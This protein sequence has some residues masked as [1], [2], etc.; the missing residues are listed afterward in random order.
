ME[1]T[2]N[3]NENLINSESIELKESTYHIPVYKENS[4]EFLR[5]LAKL[6]KAGTLIGAPAPPVKHS[7]NKIDI[8]LLGKG[9]TGYMNKQPIAVIN[10]PKLSV[11]Y[12]P[13]FFVIFVKNCKI[14]I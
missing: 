3:N 7:P 5:A 11:P 13:N 14:N 12:I 9:G 8:M 6:I 2:D 4:K 1:T 10:R